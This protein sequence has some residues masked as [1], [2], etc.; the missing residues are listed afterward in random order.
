[1][2]QIT[3][4]VGLGPRVRGM[5]IAAA[6]RPVVPLLD[7]DTFTWTP[8]LSAAE[9]TT[10]NDIVTMAQFGLAASISVTE[11]QAIKPQLAEIR[12]F[13]QRTLATWNGLT[14]AQ[15]EADEISYLNDL[16]DIL[17]ALLRS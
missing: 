12:T 8:D 10:F 17:R 16:T 2:T 14:A 15:R 7:G 1:M 6:F 11:F 9:T 13:R 3:V 4:P 5:C